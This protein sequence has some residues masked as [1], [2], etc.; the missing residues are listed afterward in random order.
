MRG[1]NL[2]SFSLGLFTILLLSSVLAE[3][4]INDKPLYLEYENKSYFPI[5]KTYSVD[6]FGIS[7]QM[8]VDYQ[9][10][11]SAKIKFAVWPLLVLSPYKSDL[12]LESFPSAPSRTH[13]W[14]TDDRGRDLFVRLI[15]GFRNT[16]FFA[17]SCVAISYLL[18]VSIGALMGFFGGWCDIVLMRFVELIESIP[19]LFMA[20][21]LVSVFDP[22]IYL[23][24]IYVSLLGWV[25]VAMMVRAHI[26]KI[27]YVE[28]AQAAKTL[29]MSDLQIIIKH[30]IPNCYPQIFSQIPFSIFQFIIFLTLV[31]FLGMGLKPPMASLGEIFQQAQVHALTAP[32]I[33]WI[34]TLFMMG[35][36][37]LLLQIS[38]LFI[39]KN[40]SN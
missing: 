22:G 18:G 25:K 8:V 27:R 37:F 20:L 13:L 35:V 39:L 16:I 17:L 24:A 21:I 40:K 14:G 5:F 32:W 26:N 29:G 15:Y 6:D 23:L 11:D 4:W 12:A 31:D 19:M 9:L 36:L 28:F 10:L 33:F 34:P 38:R 7:D 1:L 2:K 30:L 3:L